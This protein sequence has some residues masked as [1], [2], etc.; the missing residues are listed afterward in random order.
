MLAASASLD[1]FFW[2]AYRAAFRLEANEA[3]S[4]LAAGQP[5]RRFPW[6]L[7][8]TVGVVNYGT[9]S[10]PS[11]GAGASTT[12]TGSTS[13]AATSAVSMAA[14]GGGGGWATL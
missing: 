12:G 3:L 11:I 6:Q 7:D 2:E 14:G 5:R 1:Q 9:P 8:G 13:S 4:G 10:L